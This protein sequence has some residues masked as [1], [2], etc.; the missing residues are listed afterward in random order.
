M[1]RAMAN[2]SRTIRVPV[3][4]VEKE[5]RVK[6][7]EAVL[8]AELGRDPTDEEVL[9]RVEDV[10]AKDIESLRN[11]KPP[12]SLQLELGEDATLEQFVEDP[13]TQYEAEDSAYEVMRSERIQEA[14]EGLNYNERT[15]IEMRFGLRGGVPATLEQVSQVINVSKQR[16]GQIQ[17]AALSKLAAQGQLSDYRPGT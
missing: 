11:A 5:K 9:G 7:A 6:A 8:T 13:R 2:K 12:V 4:M 15:V 16:V 3:H 14:L 17:K 10:S 1:E